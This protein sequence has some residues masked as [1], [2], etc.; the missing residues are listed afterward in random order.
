MHS[1]VTKINNQFN[2]LQNDVSYIDLIVVNGNITIDHDETFPTKP[3]GCKVTAKRKRLRKSK[4][5]TAYNIAKSIV[6]ESDIATL[7]IPHS[8]HTLISMFMDT[9]SGDYHTLEIL[10]ILTI[11]E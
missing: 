11:H 9:Y 6:S 8:L 1:I 3:Q 5:I 2:Q 7:D 10:D 4:D